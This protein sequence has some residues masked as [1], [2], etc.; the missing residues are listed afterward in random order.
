MDQDGQFLTFRIQGMEQV[1]AGT[2]QDF[3][4]AHTRREASVLSIRFV[5]GGQYG[6]EVL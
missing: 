6:S 3:K 1:V 5:L 4:F 2:G